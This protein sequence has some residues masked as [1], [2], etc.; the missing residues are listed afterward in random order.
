MAEPPKGNAKARD[1]KKAAL[2]DAALSMVRFADV[3]MALVMIDLADHHILSANSAAEAMFGMLPD[4]LIGRH[5]KEFVAST[6]WEAT[7]QAHNDVR[8]GKLDGYQARRTFVP[9]RGKPF[10]AEAWV[11][12]LSAPIGTFT[13]LM[14]INVDVFDRYPVSGKGLIRDDGQATLMLIMDHD[15]V[16]ERASADSKHVLDIASDELIGT[17][18]LG[19]VHPGDAPNIFFAVSRA[20]SSYRSVA[21][22]VRLRTALNEWR[23]TVSFVNLLCEHS[24]PRLGIMAVVSGDTDFSP[25][26]RE[27]ELQQ[28]LQRIAVEIRAAEVL[29]HL[30]DVFGQTSPEQMAALTSRQWEILSRLNRGENAAK[31]AAALYLSPSTVRNH[32]SVLY[33]Q[34]GVH[35][36]VEL[37]SRFRSPGAIEQSDEPAK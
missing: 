1:A 31:I 37:L 26:P 35:S 16:V 30:P 7:V 19:L 11:R 17:P 12:R 6:D 22:R 27:S 25:K 29:I 24:P 36:Q 28:R 3:S 32:L 34:F 23:D 2:D 20:T 18:F 15:W 8:E 21:C 13:A 14:A 4:S 5:E 9:R 10:E 33:R